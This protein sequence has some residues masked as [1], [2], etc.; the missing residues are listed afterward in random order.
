VNCDPVRP[1]KPGKDLLL[2]TGQ[3]IGFT[4]LCNT[5][6]DEHG[7]FFATR[8]FMLLLPL[9]PLDRHHVRLLDEATNAGFTS[10]STTTSYR[11]L[12]RSHLRLTEIL[13]TYLMFWVILPVML[14]GPIIIG[15]IM[16]DDPSGELTVMI[17]AGVSIVMLGVFLGAFSFY[18]QHWRPV[19][20]P[21][22]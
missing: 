7:R 1:P 14:V 15:V 19:R 3:G 21:C 17:G 13:R 12:G 10:V 11:I 8:W 9:I 18:K 20:Y 6:P 2:G 16:D 22:K 4:L 5:G